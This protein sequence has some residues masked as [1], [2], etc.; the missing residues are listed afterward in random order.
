[1]QLASDYPYKENQGKCV[2]NKQKVAAKISS[3]GRIKENDCEAL[4]DAVAMQPTVVQVAIGAFKFYRGGVMSVDFCGTNTNT[5]AVVVG[6]GT[7]TSVGK[8]FYKVRLSWGSQ[9]GEAGYIR[10]DRNVQTSTGMCGL[11]TRGLYPVI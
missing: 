8:D 3:Y 11:C 1:M 9:F 2:F 7:D 6:Y 4:L 5:S 10:L